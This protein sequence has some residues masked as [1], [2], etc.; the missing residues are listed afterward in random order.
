MK[1]FFIAVA[2]SAALVACSDKQEPTGKAEAAKPIGDVN[3]GKIIAEKSCKTC[4][5]LDGKGVAPAIPHLA[6]QRARYLLA[7]LI[8]YK[9]RQR[10]HAALRDLTRD[11]SDADMRN[12]AAYYAAQPPVVNAAASDVKH[13]S[14]YEAGKKLAAACTQCHGVDG[15]STVPG[16]PSLAGQQPHY[17]VAAIQEYHQA[18]R[19]TPAMKGILGNAS[20]LE[21][22]NLALYFA[23]QTPVKRTDKNH[24]GN[25]KAGEPLT[26][27]CGGCHG[28]RG[29]SADAATPS[30][31]G[32]DAEYLIRSTKSYRTI[33][34]NWGMQRYVAGL[35]D[36]EVEDI[37]AF[38]A[39][40]E[41][42]AA[43]KV[44]TSTEELAEKCNRCHDHE[45]PGMAAPKMRG[46]DK[47]YLVM[48]LRAYRDGKRESSTMHRM[49]SPY[50]NAII[51]SLAAWYATQPAK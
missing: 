33:R 44:P 14:A 15:N 36:K 28:T 47:D 41:P 43:D 11:M 25:P 23:A 32:Q 26:A 20:K 45:N 51:E 29:V 6:A 37:A 49:S 38:Y 7:S 30:L 10:T 5:G 40:Q 4:H 17:L 9:N 34:K 21:L 2:L 12:I 42:R 35:S 46:Q 27:M 13:S 1:N 22:E 24:G 31:A 3:A 39:T 8:E 50:S 16:T 48:A 19:A 18:E